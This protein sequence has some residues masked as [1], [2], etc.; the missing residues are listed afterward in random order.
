MKLCHSLS[1]FVGAS[2]SLII[3]DESSPPS[4]YSSSLSMLFG[5]LMPDATLFEGRPLG[6]GGPLRF[7]AI[8]VAFNALVTSLCCLSRSSKTP[9]DVDEAEGGF[10]L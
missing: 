3:S 5:V 1:Y 10:V 4:E 8:V 7:G 9:R 2:R 6:P